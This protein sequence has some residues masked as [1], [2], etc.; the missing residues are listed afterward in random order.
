M[1]GGRLRVGLRNGLGDVGLGAAGDGADVGSVCLDD[2][3][4][5]RRPL[6]VLVQEL[7]IGGGAY[8]LLACRRVRPD[9]RDL[10]PRGRVRQ[11]RLG[12]M[13]GPGSARGGQELTGQVVHRS[14]GRGVEGGRLSRAVGCRTGGCGSDRTAGRKGDL[15]QRGRLDGGVQGAARRRRRC[16]ALR[17]G[18][19]HRGGTARRPLIGDARV[20]TITAL[21]WGRHRRCCLVADRGSG[22]QG[23]GR[24]QCPE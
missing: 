7:L 5:A 20:R 9:V 4:A 3:L 12:T 10:R 8:R 22:R 15:G 14:A 1:L 2:V 19:V 17:R 6:R 16:V 23:D 21:G 18:A 13:S 11:R 24:E